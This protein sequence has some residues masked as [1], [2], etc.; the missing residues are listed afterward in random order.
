VWQSA[1]EPVVELLPEDM[2][3]FLDENSSTEPRLELP[4]WLH[5]ITNGTD[6]SGRSIAP[7]RGA[8]N[9]NRLVQ[10]WIERWGRQSVPPPEEE[11]EETHGE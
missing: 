1:G 11:I 8:N 2:N 3:A 7:E 9:T 4:W 10:R 5:R 6:E